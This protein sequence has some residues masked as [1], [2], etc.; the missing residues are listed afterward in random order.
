MKIY[1]R[2]PQIIEAE[3]F[4]GNQP[5]PNGVCLCTDNGFWGLHVHGD[6]GLKH[7]SK[8]CWV[9]KLPTGTYDCLSSEDFNALYRPL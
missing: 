1:E 6:D 3:E 8:G 4:T 5:W 9:I 7:V 2:K